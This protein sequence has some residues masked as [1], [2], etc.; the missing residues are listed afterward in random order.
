MAIDI[1]RGTT[2]KP[3]AT[4]ALERCLAGQPGLSGELFIGYPIIVTPAGSYTIDALL[5]SQDTGIV[6]F[7]LVEGTNPEG[8]H[9]R[10]DE[11]YNQLEARLKKYSELVHRRSLLI[12]IQ[13]VSFAPALNRAA[14]I[15]SDTYPIADEGTLLARLPKCDPLVDSS[16]YRS[17]LSVIESTSTIRK[18]RTR[19]IV[20]KETSRGAKLKSLEDSIATLDSIQNKAVIETVEG[21]QRIRGLAGSG[22]TIVLALKAA[23]LHAQHPDWRIAVT[24]NTRSLKGFFRRLITIFCLEQTGEEP[25]WTNLRVVN[26]WGAPGGTER[27]GIYYEFCRTNDVTYFDFRSARAQFGAGNPFG[28]ACRRAIRQAGEAKRIY[29][30]VLV[31]EAQD[32]S[33]AFLQLCY[34]SLDAPKRLI[35]AYDELQNLTGTSLPSPDLIF[36]ENTNGTDRVRF[37]GDSGRTMRRDIILE[38][39]YRNS[40]PVLVTAHALGFG[41]YRTPL[42]SES[43][44]LVQM[45]DQAQLWEEIGYRR[46]H[47]RLHPGSDVTLVRPD[48]TSPPFLHG[49]SPIEDLIEFRR[50]ETKRQQ[51]DWLVQQ[52]ETNLAQDELRHDDIIVINPDPIS[53]RTEVGPIRRRLLEAGIACHVAGADTDPDYFNHPDS[54]SITF[55]GIHRAKGNEAGMVYII[56]AQ[57][58]HSST[59]NLARLRNRLFTAITRSKSWIRV[60]GIGTNMQALTDEYETLKSRGFQ[61]QFRYPTEDEREHLRIVHRDMSDKELEHLRK[62]DEILSSLLS[63]LESGNVNVEDLDKDLVGRLMRHLGRTT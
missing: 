49:H 16:I 10:Q 58:C 11:S 21:V 55:T 28:G 31:D 9:E 12:P 33:P 22:K 29:D 40:R 5:I 38:K 46:N 61:L 27:D 60:L 20:Q 52:I 14:A 8:F 53:T 37:D 25:D 4:E 63:D 47:G 13:P 35:Y 57:D 6:V 45:F 17:A 39:C 3:A 15:D 51:A 30:V 62:R 54:E 48:T 23:Y 32:F 41:I 42:A 36:G 26:A 59:Y 18:S 24:F 7:D 2:N 19:R 34:E 43:T 44:G 50:F 56:N 1:V